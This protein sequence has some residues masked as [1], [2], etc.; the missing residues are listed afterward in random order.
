[1][2]GGSSSKT[3]SFEQSHKVENEVS[4]TNRNEAARLAPWAPVAQDM[5]D[6]AAAGRGLYQSNPTGL[7]AMSQQA[8]QGLGQM[9]DF[10]ASRQE[11]MS[12]S[13]VAR[14]SIIGM[15]RNQNLAQRAQDIYN[16]ASASE[17]NLQ[18]TAQGKYLSGANPYMDELIQ[19]SQ[20]DAASQV[21]T[22]FAASGRYGSGNFSTAIADTT[23]R[24]ATEARMQDY[25]Q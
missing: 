3:Q 9:A 2:G 18:D 12:A 22:K 11:G 24:I 16:T 19:T 8:I 14:N 25:E 1:M 23:G 4:D 10:Y 7:G 17:Q 20:R 15:L 6:I 13:D 5:T 21:A